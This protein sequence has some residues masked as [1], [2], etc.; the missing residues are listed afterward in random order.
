[1]TRARASD[2]RDRGATFVELLV[3]IVLI[4]LVVTGVM[5]ALT[6]SIQS[7]DQHKSKIM[8]LA[9]L[10]G[11]AAHL[12]RVFA[13][14]SAADCSGGTPPAASLFDTELTNAY[15]SGGPLDDPNRDVTVSVMSPV[16]CTANDVSLVTLRSEHAKQNASETLQVTVG[17]VTVL[18]DGDMSVA[19]PPGSCVWG[20]PDIDQRNPEIRGGGRLNTTVTVTL[21]YTG[22]CTSEAVTLEVTNV[23]PAPIYPAT[24]EPM[25]LNGDAASGEFEFTFPKNYYSPWQVGPVDLRLT[26]STSD[27]FTDF[28]TVI[29]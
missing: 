29:P 24:T 23:P 7:S 14:D 12:N 18:E 17:G 2:R 10:E 8:A 26:T 25:S 9:E 3:S 11:A 22:D 6:V 15:S 13:Y 4:G 21:S 1:M 28:F 16:A 20:G 19:P 5:T 27:V